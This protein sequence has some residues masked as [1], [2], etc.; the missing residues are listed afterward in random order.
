MMVA[1]HGFLRWRLEILLT[2]K[3]K[4]PQQGESSGTTLKIAGRPI[5]PEA[6]YD[7]V[8]QLFGCVKSGLCHSSGPAFVSE[9]K[10][11]TSLS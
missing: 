1:L 3:K 8:K 10:V 7:S 2:K 5:V 6:N 9:G 11:D 4:L